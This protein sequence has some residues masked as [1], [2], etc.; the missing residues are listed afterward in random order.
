MKTQNIFR[1]LMLLCMLLCLSCFSVDP[2]IFNDNEIATETF[3]HDIAVNNQ[4]RLVLE[5]INGA[6]NV[7]GVSGLTVVKI[8]GERRVSA[9]TKEDAAAYL[10]Q[11]QVN[12]SESSNEI[13]VKSEQPSKSE[14]KTYEIVYAIEIPDSWEVVISLLNGNVAVQNMN[15]RVV[16]GLTNGNIE[17]MAIDG[18]I[19]VDLVNGNIDGNITLPL[20]ESCEMKSINGQIKL[21][22]P[23]DTSAKLYAKTVNGTVTVTGLTMSNIQ[24]SRNMMNGILND[25]NG[26]ITLSVTN[27]LINVN[28]F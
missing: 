17:L 22:I 16:I 14:G 8:A 20:N 7:T 12:I 19:I 11:L 27:G 1:S 23:H 18:N 13:R 4:G 9:E 3:S 28:G 25:G 24:S 26:Q 15:A 21:Q 10:E 5:G 2:E 6:V